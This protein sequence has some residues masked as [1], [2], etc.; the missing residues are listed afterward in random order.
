MPCQENRG[1]T[2]Q[3]DYKII[4]SSVPEKPVSG[5]FNSL[6]SGVHWK[7]THTYINL[8]LS[9]AGFYKYVRPLSGH[10]ALRSYKLV[11]SNLYNFPFNIILDQ[12]IT[13][14]RP[15]ILVS[16]QTF[17]FSKSTIVS[18][19]KKLKDGESQQ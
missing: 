18:L 11:E 14:K 3:N 5:I 8:K 12:F 2:H 10:R 13:F 1:W 17:S 19:E 15:N 4:K 6:V 7:A 9:G 16:Q